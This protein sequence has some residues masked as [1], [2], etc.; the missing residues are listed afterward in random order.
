RS[1]LRRSVFICGPSLLFL[2]ASV[3]LWQ[4]ELA[5]RKALVIGAA[6]SGI[7]S[8]RFLAQRG[9]T[10][11]LNDRKP[12]REWSQEALDLKTGG[13]G[14]G[15]GYG[16]CWL[17]GQ[18]DLVVGSPGVPAKLIPIRYADRRGAEVIGEIELASR[19]LRGRIVAVTGTNG[20]T[21][22]T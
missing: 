20:K 12:L 10:V 13:V 9:A 16:A 4:M 19:F 22:T 14:L 5:G 1:Y 15:G 2:C 21:T 11:A 17:L 18:V 3:P 7:A 8:A 6:R